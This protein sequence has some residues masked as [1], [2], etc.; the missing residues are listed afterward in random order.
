[1]ARS[2]DDDRVEVLEHSR[3]YQGFFSMDLYRLRHRTFAGGW[4]ETLS[5]EVFERGHAAAVVLYDPARDQ[6]VLI[7]QFRIGAYTAGLEPWL[8][9]AVAGIIE[10]G[11]AAEAVVIRE[12]MEEAGCEVTALEPIGRYLMSPGGCSETIALYCGRVEASGAGGLY[13]LTEEG[14]DIRA[15]ALP[16]SEV[17]TRL[18]AGE[19][20]SAHT[21]IC[22]Q[23]LTA[24]REELM[25]RWK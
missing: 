6:V 14:E 10:P 21:V 1:M 7:E 5:R 4:T 22:L 12:S 11:E 16:W 2:Q 17:E 15:V 20:L 3:P 18:N 13:G 9:E 8:L 23:W 24:H 25:E 19:I